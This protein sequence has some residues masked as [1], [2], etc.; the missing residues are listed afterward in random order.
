MSFNLRSFL[1][2][3]EA[4][5]GDLVG[6][7]FLSPASIIDGSSNYQ[8]K[9][10]ARMLGAL[11]RAAQRP[12]VPLIEVKWRQRFCPDLCVIN[13]AEHVLAV[14]EY[15]ST[16]SSDER[17][18]GKD[19]YHFEQVIKDGKD[20]VEAGVPLPIYWIMISTP[21][22]CPVKKWP[23]YEWNTLVDYPPQLKDRKIRNASP[24][25]Y[26]EPGLHEACDAMWRRV[27]EVVGDQPLTNVAWV[28]MGLD[29]RL[30]VK[31]LNGQPQ[32]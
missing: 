3:L 5:I 25:R 17:L 24:Y 19:L 2:S 26:Y 18:V 7:K 16:N 27:A 10:H 6:R 23:W 29:L 32:S 12:L 14:V 9:L 20:D 11:A 30:E 21:P 28:N 15:E 22:D 8:S 1:S 31:N 13:D 4:E